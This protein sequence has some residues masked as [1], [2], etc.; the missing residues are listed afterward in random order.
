[1]IYD[2]NI[3]KTKILI[4]NSIIYTFKYDY[5]YIRIYINLKG[6]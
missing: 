2:L 4:L 5:K 3:I 6:Y 1:M